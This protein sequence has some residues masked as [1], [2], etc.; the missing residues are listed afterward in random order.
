MSLSLSLL[1]IQGD[2]DTN[3][4]IVVSC[5]RVFRSVHLPVNGQTLHTCVVLA[6]Y[7][8]TELHNY[9]RRSSL[10]ADMLLETGYW[11][12]LYP[13]CYC[14]ALSPTQIRAVLQLSVIL[15]SFSLCN[16]GEVLPSGP[17]LEP[18]GHLS[19]SRDRLCANTLLRH[20]E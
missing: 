3:V 20:L 5:E 16:L 18:E 7:H 11:Y 1:P 4:V 12:W 9:K 15:M 10:G 14:T 17:S 6:A 13:L 2:N 19:S 8:P